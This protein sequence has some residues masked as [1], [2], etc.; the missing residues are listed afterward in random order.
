MADDL[1]GKGPYVKIDGQATDLTD[2]KQFQLAMDYATSK[3]S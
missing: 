2:E 1:L 3:K